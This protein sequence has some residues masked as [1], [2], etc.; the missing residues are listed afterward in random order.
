M[1]ASALPPQFPVSPQIK[2]KKEREEEE[3]LFPLL[4]S[5][6]DDPQPCTGITDEGIL[7]PPPK[8]ERG[9]PAAQYPYLKAGWRSCRIDGPRLYDLLNELPL[10]PFGVLAWSIVDTEEELFELEDMRDEDKVIFALWNRWIML[11]RCVSVL[12]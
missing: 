9:G 11:N 12:G 10:E 5:H 3:R 8:E 4:P 2:H 6:V 1:A 7:I